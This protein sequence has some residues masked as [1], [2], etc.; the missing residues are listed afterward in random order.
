MSADQV[1]SSRQEWFDVLGDLFGMTFKDV[2]PEELDF[3]WERVH[4]THEVFL[5][6]SAL[7]HPAA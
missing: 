6:R 5:A 4:A 1:L 2:A 7:S 3:L